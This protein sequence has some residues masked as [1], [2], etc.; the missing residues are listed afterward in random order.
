MQDDRREQLKALLGES[1]FLL[2][3]LGIQRELLTRGRLA[4]L[5]EHE[6]AISNVDRSRNLRAYREKAIIPA[7]IG[8]YVHDY[9][10]SEQRES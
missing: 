4:H 7:M 6:M 8:S 3:K 5:L 1:T 2:E 9:P 10:F